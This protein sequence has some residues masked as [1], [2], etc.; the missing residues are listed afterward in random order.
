MNELYS[1]LNLSPDASEDDVKKAYRRLSKRHHPDVGGDAEV[2]REVQEAYDVLSDPARRRRYDETGS[3]EDNSAKVL[4]LLRNLVV[5]CA[6]EFE[7]GETDVVKVMRDIIESQL[8]TCRSKMVLCKKGAEKLRK[9]A[10][11]IKVADGKPNVL[12]DAIT[13]KAQIVWDSVKAGKLEESIM[14]EALR[15]LADYSCDVDIDR[16]YLNAR[17]VFSHRIWEDL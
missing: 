14:V 15:V 8:E 17:N 10:Q 11:K 13:A 4:S 1:T 7:P 9:A 6:E 5:Q 16:K 12:R 3:A 2:F